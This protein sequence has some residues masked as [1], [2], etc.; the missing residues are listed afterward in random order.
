MSTIK[1]EVDI[2]G[3]S[4]ASCQ[5]HVQQALNNESGIISANV[6]LATHKALLTF[7]SDATNLEKIKQVVEQAGYQMIAE[8]DESIAEE[9]AEKSFRILKRKTILAIICC[10][11]LAIMAMIYHESRFANYIMWALATP[12][13]YFG[14]QFFT[15]AYK[16]LKNK[17]SNMDTLVSLSTGIAYLFSIS[18]TLFP[19]FWLSHNMEPHVYFETVGMVITFVLIG[20]YLED[21][22]K[23]STATA[24]KDLIGLQPKTAT[25]VLNGEFKE[26]PINEIKVGDE[27]VVKAGEKIAVDGKVI[28]GTTFVDESMITGEPLPAEKEIGSKIYSGTINQSGNIHYLAEKVGNETLLAQIIKLVKEAQGS[29]APIQKKVDKIA[30]IFVPIV[31]IIALITLTAWIIFSP[32]N[33]FV[34]GFLSMITVLIIACPCALGL[35]TPT[36]I[37]VGVGKAAKEGILIKDAIAL[38][39]IKNLTTIVLDKTGTITEGKP[40]VTAIQWFRDET[41]ELTNI[42]YSME[43]YSQHP[44]AHAICT[45]YKEKATVLQNIEM[46]TVEGKG[47]KASYNNEN[48]YIGNLPFIKDENITLQTEEE[49]YLRKNVNSTMVL[50]ANTSGVIAIISINDAIKKSSKVSIEA[51]KDLNLKVYMLTGDNEKSASAIAKEVGI[52]NIHANVNP[53]EKANFIKEQ[54]T[55][56]EKVAMIGDGINDSA[57]LATADISIAM[58]HGSDIA[59]NV[60]QITIISSDLMKIS[61]AIKLSKATVTTINQNLFWAFIYNIIG[62]PL[63]AGILYPINGFLLNPMIAGAAMALSSVSVVTNSLRLKFKNF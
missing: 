9:I 52:T 41:P 33:G 35:A 5:A 8:E 16:Q 24:I 7:D 51:L 50:F 54:Q 10:I 30:G 36:A 25:I 19:D 12:F 40:Q 56:G 44:L 32:T 63:A 43:S 34:Q 17:S 49:N 1:K 46:K 42:L 13:L 18:T 39:T 31:V 55:K 27:I 59:I 58:G 14:S 2:L 62:I 23:K 26:I 53:A 21:Q 47:I 61:K 6:N 38:E 4:C 37:M 48:Y 45:Y 11:P 57:A 28:Q 3:M 20:R 29:Q 22:A 15:G 60:A